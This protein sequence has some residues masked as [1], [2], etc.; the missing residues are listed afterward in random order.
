M[1]LHELIVQRRIGDRREMKNGVELFIA[2]LFAPIE[3]GQVLSDEIAAITGEIFEVAGAKI[4]DYGYFC[5]GKFFL[6]RERE[7]RADESGATGDSNIR[8]GIR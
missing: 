2:K 8:T 3:R 7:I 4:V 5:L 1:H 6:E